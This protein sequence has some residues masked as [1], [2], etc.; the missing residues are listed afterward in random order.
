M[1]WTSILAVACAFIAGVAVA[2][3]WSGDS[4]ER[5]AV[6]PPGTMIAPATPTPLSTSAIPAMPEH[7]NSA[8]MP[9]SDS[10]SPQYLA[11]VWARR[12]QF[13]RILGLY[14]LMREMD[15]PAL[16]NLLEEASTLSGAEYMQA[17]TIIIGRLAELDAD[18][19]LDTALADSTLAQTTWI[20][21]IFATLARSDVSA[22]QAGL[23]RLPPGLRRLAESSMAMATNT[24]PAFANAASTST[25]AFGSISITAPTGAML[26]INRAPQGLPAD[27]NLPSAWQDA[28]NIEN[29]QQRLFALHQIASQW[30]LSDP[31]A[32]LT[33]S[34]AVGDSMIA[35][36]V[37]QQVVTQWAQT[38]PEAALRWISAQPNSQQMRQMLAMA[39]QLASRQNFNETQMLVDGLPDGQREYGQLGLLSAWAQQDLQEA[40][41]WVADLPQGRIR[42][43]ALQN[44]ASTLLQQDA[45]KAQEWLL[46][47]PQADAALVSTMAVAMLANTNVDN[48][49]EFVDAIE[50][51][52]NR[53][54][55]GQQLV[56]TLGRN[57]PE[58]AGDWIEQQPAE[59]RPALYAALMNSWGRVA[60]QEALVFAESLLNETQRD[61]A[62]TGLAPALTGDSAQRA[63]DQIED[64]TLQDQARRSV[65]W[66]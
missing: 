4:V 23:E 65:G 39:A 54:N 9:T 51:A 36:N 27:K 56:R 48:A 15:A 18:L 41:A 64:A 53:A 6:A 45:Q 2:T 46:S 55:A 47:L 19:A 37:Q 59:Q 20:S 60:P 30:A 52:N 13:E 38:D 35:R 61:H 12:S 32:A 16:V 8:N 62:L 34:E 40:Q 63:I 24:Q 14:D 57:T 11:D 29:R 49:L 7:R 31:Q 10:L 3:F 21:T 17:T 28:L 26:G 44:V 42:S 1:N 22:A 58:R 33:A 50:D 66:N 5:Q 43:Q 25:L